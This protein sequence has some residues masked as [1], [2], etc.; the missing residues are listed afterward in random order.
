MH[1]YCK[2]QSMQTHIIGCWKRDFDKI[3]LTNSKNKSLIWIYGWTRWATRWQLTQFRWIGSLPTN[4]S[5]VDSPGI[6]TTW[7]ANL[8]NGSVWTLTRSDC[9]EP[10]P[11]LFATN[12]HSDYPRCKTWNGWH[13]VDAYFATGV[14]RICNQI[15][16]K[17][18]LSLPPEVAHDSLPIKKSNSVEPGSFD[19]CK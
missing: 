2:L 10:L 15:P 18:E 19:P 6:V 1:R 7:T 11:T 12:S 13:S 3:L 8:A 17:R 9:P 5:R 14:S 4:R 16:K